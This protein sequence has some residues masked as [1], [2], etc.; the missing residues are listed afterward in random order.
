[1]ETGLSDHHKM[2]ITVLRSFFQKKEPVKINYRDYKLFDISLF[3]TE[4]KNRLEGLDKHDITYEQ[5][6]YTFMEVLNTHAPMKLKYV[7]ANN[8]PFMNKNISKA[9]MKRSRLRNKFLSNPNDNNKRIYNK[10]RNY[11]VNL[12]RKEKKKYYNN[13]DL[14]LLTDNK[15]FW[16][17]IKPLFSDKNNI[18][19]KINNN[20]KQCN[21][22]P[23]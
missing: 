8:A 17:T 10:H 7:R 19:R 5:F 12:L 6:E 23:K 9:I 3:R 1:M 16:K 13:I 11:C 4:L 18:S 2:T 15:L 20:S 21:T 14:K 22:Y